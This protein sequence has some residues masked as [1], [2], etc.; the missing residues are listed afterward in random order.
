[1]LTYAGGD[2]LYVPVENLDVLEPLWREKRG[3][4]AGQAGRRG[5]AEAARASRNASARS[6]MSC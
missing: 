6:R 5:L 2:K 1:M 3:R 4:G